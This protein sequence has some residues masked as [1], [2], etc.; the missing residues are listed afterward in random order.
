[1][2]RVLVCGAPGSAGQVQLVVRMVPP[3]GVVVPGFGLVRS[4][5]WCARGFS[6]AHENVCM[7]AGGLP[8]AGIYGGGVGGLGASGEEAD[9]PTFPRQMPVLVRISPYVYRPK[10]S[11][12]R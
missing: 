1:V 11:N 2:L 10:L 3:S 6:I 12:D 5:S 4:S 9:G 7:C 8:G